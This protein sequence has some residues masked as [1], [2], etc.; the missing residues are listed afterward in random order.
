MDGTL[1]QSVLQTDWLILVQRGASTFE[2]K[3]VYEFQLQGW[4][5]LFPIISSSIIS[6]TCYVQWTFMA[7][8]AVFELG[9]L[10]CGVATS[11]KMLIV[12]RAIAGMASSGIMGGCFTIIAG[13]VP[14]A[15]RPCMLLPQFRVCLKTHSCYSSDRNSYGR[16]VLAYPTIDCIFTTGLVSNLGLVMGP[17][18]GGALTEYTTWRWCKLRLPSIYPFV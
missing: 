4:Q 14:M 11:S 15:K 18:I 6:L 1:F 13:C 5:R 2:W 17:L 9:S 3:V 8:F 10:I 7:F 16:Y 12:G